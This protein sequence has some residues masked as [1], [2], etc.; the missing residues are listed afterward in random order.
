M[1]D[2]TIQK[3]LDQLVKLSNELIEEAQKRYGQTGQLYYDA[4]GSFYL[5]SGDCLGTGKQRQ[6]YIKFHSEKM[7]NLGAGAW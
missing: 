2:V 3:K 5:M 1:T 6:E 4:G 7:C